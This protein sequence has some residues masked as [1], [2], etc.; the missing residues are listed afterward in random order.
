[1][2]IAHD[3]NCGNP[4]DQLEESVIIVNQN[5][6]PVPEGSNITFSCPPGRVLIGSNMAECME[7]GEWEPNP[8]EVKCSGE[9]S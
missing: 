7:N 5:V 3:N 2:Y 4:A 9:V 1:M 8:W 6:F